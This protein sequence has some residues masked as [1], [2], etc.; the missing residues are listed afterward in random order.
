MI[1]LRRYIFL[2]DIAQISMLK[3]D[4][5]SN[6][7]ITAINFLNDGYTTVSTS[8]AHLNESMKIIII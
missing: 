4:K 1:S 2:I 8:P 3:N 6:V 7:I 5:R